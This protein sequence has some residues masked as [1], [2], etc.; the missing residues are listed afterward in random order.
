MSI[1][2]ALYSMVLGLGL[3]M[4]LLGAWRWWSLQQEVSALPIN[5]RLGGPFILPS[6]LGRPVN[7]KDYLGQPI[8]LNFGF[9]SCPDICPTVLARLKHVLKT[10]DAEGG[11]AQVLFVS[12]DP[13]RDSLVHLKDYMGFFD[14]RMVAATG[15]PEQVAAVAK[16]YGV[17]YHREDSGSAAGYGFAHSDYIYLLDARGRLRKL[18]DSRADSAEMVADVQGLNRE[19]Q[20]LFSWALR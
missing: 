13:E 10:L 20:G 12:F 9:T 8:L 15:T 3:L 18:Y 17:V 19:S 5:T 4:G 7:T 6:T 16:Q 1:R 11:Q 14:R 2:Q